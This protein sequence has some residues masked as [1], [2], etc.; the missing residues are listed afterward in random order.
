ME[1]LAI[2]ELYLQRQINEGAQLFDEVSSDFLIDMTGM[3]EFK[4]GGE[5]SR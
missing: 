5:I 1:D 3:S 2:E 4:L